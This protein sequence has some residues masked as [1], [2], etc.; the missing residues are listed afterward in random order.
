MSQLTK[1]AIVEATVHL[2][3]TRPL[4]RITVRDI[5]EMC[6]ITRNTFYYHF[7]DIYEAL[8]CALDTAFESLKHTEGDD[9]EQ[10]LFA[11][12]DFFVEKKRLLV[13][14]YRAIGGEQLS[15]YVSKQLRAILMA[16]LHK[17]SDGLEVDAEDLHVICT[18]YE[19]AMIGI[20]LRWIRNDKKERS[21]EQLRETLERVHRI[22][23]G[24][25]RL[26]LENCRKRSGDRV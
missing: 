16:Q 17:A 12:I 14:L 9:Y 25:L 4:N 1:K 18:F 19:E 26:C 10:T 13:S 23:D 8:E 6:G 5:V 11:V 22:F 21:D 2:A 3:Q 15:D 24:H 20:L 7:H